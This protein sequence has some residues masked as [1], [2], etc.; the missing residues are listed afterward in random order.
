MV[1]IK[2]VTRLLLN[3]IYPNTCLICHRLV[4]KEDETI[5][6]NCWEHFEAIPKENRVSSLYISQ[7]LDSVYS[8]WYF[9][10]QFDHVIHSLKYTDRAKLGLELGYHLG[11]FLRIE[12][13]N[14]IDSITAVP[15]HRTKLRDR[16]YNQAEWIGK[17][18]AKMWQIPFDNK[19]LKRTLYTV[20]QTTLNRQERLENMAHAF[21]VIKEVNDLSIL[22]VDDVLT[23]GATT[24]ACAVALKE[25]GATQVHVAT[26]SAPSN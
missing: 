19:M 17:G 23:T 9:K 24:S 7:G 6:S 4:H 26:L 15:L 18:I 16:G 21:K 12:D 13:F 22:I 25:A 11:K 8:G 10:N 3:L 1:S 2:I 14:F 5:C 20:S